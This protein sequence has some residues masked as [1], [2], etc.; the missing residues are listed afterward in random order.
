MKLFPVMDGRRPRGSQSCREKGR[1][2]SF[3]VQA[4]EPLG[5]DSHRTMSK[6]LSGCWLLIGHK[7][8]SVLLCPIG[9]QFL[10][11][12]FHEFIHDGYCPASHARFVHHASLCVQ[13][14]LLFST[15]LTTNEGTTDELKKR[16][17]CYQQ[18]QFNLPREFFVSDS[19]QCTVNNRKLK[20]RRRRES[21]ISNS[22]TR[23]NNTFA[24]ASP[25]FVHFSA[26]NCT[27]TR[28]NA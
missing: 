2:E 12:S 13:G 25:L 26:V 24:R 17:V 6:N 10:V 19:S 21:Q 18:E 7:K 28:E 23:Q 9:E 8:C 27:T 11:S 1:D 14:K 20:M 4:K 16:L 15:F 22:L 3:Q 5:I